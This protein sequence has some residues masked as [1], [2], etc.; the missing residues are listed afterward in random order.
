MS[1]SAAFRRRQNLAV[2]QL[3]SGFEAG[4]IKKP[5]IARNLIHQ[6]GRHRSMYFGSFGIHQHRPGYHS[7]RS[8]TSP[9]AVDAAWIL[10][11]RS[12]D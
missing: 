12:A 2:E 3:H 11:R 10:N 4:Q 5:A 7:T 6:A 1:P 9:V 8:L